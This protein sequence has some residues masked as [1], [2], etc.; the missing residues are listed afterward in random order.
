VRSGS[1][2]FQLDYSLP[3]TDVSFSPVAGH[4]ASVNESGMQV[5]D[6]ESAEEVW[7]IRHPNC[8]TVHFSPDGKSLLTRCRSKVL[9]FDAETG[10]E[11]IDVK[12]PRFVVSASFGLG[13]RTLVGTWR[14][15]NAACIW[16]ASTGEEKTRLRFPKRRQA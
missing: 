2:L 15:S 4:F 13:G 6:P 3:V 16:D 12:A 14:D 7:R 10:E 11:L 1:Q 8:E 9:L 5:W